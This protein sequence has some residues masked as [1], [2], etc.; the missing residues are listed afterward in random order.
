MRYRG[1]GELVYPVDEQVLLVPV[2][3]RYLVAALSGSPVQQV[4]VEGDAQPWLSRRRY[5]E[6]SEPTFEVTGPVAGNGGL[7][8]AGTR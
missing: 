4:G 2:E 1:G 5:P 8:R 6:V 7:Y 3:E